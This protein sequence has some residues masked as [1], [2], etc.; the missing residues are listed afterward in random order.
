MRRQC[1]ENERNIL[2]NNKRNIISGNTLIRQ[3]VGYAPIILGVIFGIAISIPI[4][5]NMK[6]ESEA[7]IKSVMIGLIAVTSAVMQ[8]ILRLIMSARNKKAAFFK[9]NV[10]ING[11]TV[12]G[13]NYKNG[14]FVY[15][16]D[17]FRN[18][19]NRLARISLPLPGNVSLKAGERLIAAVEENGS[20]FLLKVDDSTANMIPQQYEYNLFDISNADMMAGDVIPHPNSVNLDK[21]PRNTS[22][23][24]KCALIGND[25]PGNKKKEVVIGICT[26]ILYY[27]IAGLVWIMLVGNEVITDFTVAVVVGAISFLGGIACIILFVRLFKRSQRKLISG[28]ITVQTVMFAGRDVSMVGTAPVDSVRIY[29]YVNGE[30]VLNTYP[31]PAINVKCDYGTVLNKYVMNK[32]VMFKPV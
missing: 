5:I 14:H 28:E 11:C 6:L 19:E 18:S 1:T 10:C 16:E 7:A 17:D 12:L 23:E 13:V 3:N 20:Y 29:E 27:M 30:L 22:H 25:A 15:V 26:A 8:A 31:N 4:A 32:R 21:A 9:G 2:L 24:E